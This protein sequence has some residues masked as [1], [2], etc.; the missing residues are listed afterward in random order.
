M[1]KLAVFLL[2]VISYLVV[3]FSFGFSTSQD[4]KF[5]YAYDEKIPLYPKERTIIAKYKEDFDKTFEELSLQ[6][7]SSENSIRWRTGNLLEITFRTDEMEE[8]IKSFLKSKNMIRSVHSV[9]TL[10]N[11]PDIIIFDEILLKFKTGITQ[12]QKDDLIAKYNL[13]YKESYEIFDILYAGDKVDALELS[14]KIYE[15]G[16]VEFS[17]PNF[18]SNFVPYQSI[19]NDPF[20]VNQVTFHNTGQV[21]TDGHSGTNDA[22]ID[23][24]EAWSITTGSN[25]IVVA[26]VD[27]GV[28]SDHPDLPNT[29]QIRLTGSDR[30]DGDANPSPVGNNNHGN[31]CAGVIGATMNNNQGIAGLAPGCR[32]MPV[33]ID[34]NTSTTSDFALAIRFA[35]ENGADIISNSWGLSDGTAPPHSPNLYPE[36]VSA[37]Q[38]AVS[39]GRSGKGCVVLFAVN[40]S[41][42]HNTGQNGYISFPANVTIAGVLSVGA[43]DRTD[44][45]ANYSPTSDP[46]HA[47]NQITDICAPSHRAY[48]CQIATETFEMWTI[49][50]PN[51]AGY[52][53]WN[54]TGFCLNP[55][56]LGSLL[57]NSGTNYLSFTG[58]FGGTSHACPV[59]AGVAALMLSVNPNLTYMQVYN[60]VTSTSDQIGGYTYT[61]GR[62]NELGS[63]RVNA[64]RAVNEAYRQILVINGNYNLF[65]TPTPYTLQYVQPTSVISWDCSSNITKCSVPGANPFSF[66]ANGNGNGWIQA[67]IPTYCGNI[68]ITKNLWVGKFES[69]VVTGTAAVC[70]GNLYTYTAQ[71][72]GGHKPG[73]SYSWTYPGNW[74]FYSQYDNVIRLQVPL[75]N[76]MYGT[77]R[78]SITNPCGASGYSGITV[79]PGY[80]G[81]SF[82][83][84][85]NPASD[86]VTV[87]IPENNVESNE[88]G[89][90]VTGI[91][92]EFVLIIYNNQGVIML[93]KKMSDNSITIPLSEFRDGSYMIEIRSGKMRSAQQLI[94]KH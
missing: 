84:Y 53:P 35:A 16:L 11:G 39:S 85:P 93:T 69:T 1:K 62:S 7:L 56:A 34:Y 63:G 52:N 38:Y 75:Y 59:V 87:D 9:Y 29:R 73:Y 18:L 82:S 3:A 76:P 30:V 33:R 54:I 37:I 74:M 28:T 89:E 42:N 26:V 20:F 44:H 36:V 49:D 58:R 22:D 48:P 55:P 88:T 86:N 31:A 15:T 71:V 68:V 14:N 2:L 70:P 41:A 91:T 4:R 12:E 92:D 83:L 80:C 43:T 65:C 13:A 67:T 61:N 81:K 50:I 47:F 5:Y 19:P 78:V 64:C 90:N 17:K 25:N 57:P 8:K 46:G 77:V 40:N 27:E 23:A 6:Q 24:P 10:K 60:I 72:P 79:Y 51:S 21:F 45:Q 32:I 66:Q 94:I